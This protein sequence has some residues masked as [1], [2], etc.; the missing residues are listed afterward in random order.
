MTNFSLEAPTVLVDMDGVLADFDQE[1]QSRLANRHPSIPIAPRSNFYI[2][3]DY[4]EHVDLVRSLSDEEGFF[5]SLP[6]V[7]N[8][9]DGWQR[10]LSNGYTPRICSSPIRT[11]QRSR[12]EKLGWLEREFVPIFGKWV[13][14]QAIIAKDKAAYDGIALIDDRPGLQSADTA[15]WQHIIFDRPYNKQSRQP[16]LYGWK[17]SN[18]LHLLKAAE[19]RH[20]EG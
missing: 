17:D 3:Q 6:V 16:R 7:D 12:Q 4:P 19:V 8:A 5:I 15:S 20:G 10:I 18:L 11:N 9:L 2:A 14:D 1:I 13:V